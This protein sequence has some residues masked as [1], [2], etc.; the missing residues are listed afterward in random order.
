MTKLTEQ[1]INEQIDNAITN[2][3]KINAI[4]PRANK[5]LFKRQKKPNYY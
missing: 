2:K 5:V 1:Q 3:A 4:E